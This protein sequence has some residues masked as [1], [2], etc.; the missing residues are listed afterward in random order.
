MGSELAVV[1]GI[2]GPAIAA[3]PLVF[4][5]HFEVLNVFSRL[6][7]LKLR[8]PKLGLLNSALTRSPENVGFRG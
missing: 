2:R 6:D 1:E 4:P 3:L 7:N 8:G 5:A